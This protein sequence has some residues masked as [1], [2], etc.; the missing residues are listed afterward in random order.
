VR[1]LVMSKL[2]DNLKVVLA[3]SFTFYLKT[4]YFHWNVEGPDFYEYHKLF[5][6]IYDEVFEAVDGIAEHIRTLD[7]YAPGSYKRF[8]ELSNIETIETIPDLKQMINILLK[9]N[10]VVMRSIVSAISEAGKD[11]MH[12][13]I[14]NFLQDR[15]DSHQKHQWMLRA[16]SKTGNKNG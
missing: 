16:S 8:Q 9:D 6:E 1:N 11:P 7:E 4:H 15:L 13:G 2:G 5:N 14:E 12:K 3:D 10:E